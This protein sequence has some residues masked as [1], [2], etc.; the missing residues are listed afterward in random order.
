MKKTVPTRFVHL[1]IALALSLLFVGT[2][3]TN[4]KADEWN[5]LTIVTFNSPVQIPGIRGTRVLSPGTYVFKLAESTANRNIVQIFNKDQTKLYATI[6]SVANSRLTPTGEAV[7]T[8]EE[9]PAG[10]TPALK[11]WFHPGRTEGHEF[12]YPKSE[13]VE[14]AREV[15]EPVLSMPE[16][17]A[18]TAKALE[19]APVM[20]E[21][22]SGQEV[23][24]S[25]VVGNA[26]STEEQAANLPQTASEMPL[27]ALGGIMLV[28]LGLGLRRLARNSS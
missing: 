11:A 21:E 10:A 12:V 22:P 24:E 16:P 14:L 25:E 13:A 9:R 1:A 4:A 17:A 8:F 28:G 15:N 2:F 7:I 6:L 19:E 26:P 18:S 20:A 5:H 23:A 3:S 27:M